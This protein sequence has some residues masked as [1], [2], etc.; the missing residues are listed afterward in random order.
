MF[1]KFEITLHHVTKYMIISMF[2][3]IARVTPNNVN[4]SKL[5]LWLFVY[6]RS[7]D[8][9]GSEQIFLIFFFGGG[10]G[11]GGRGRGGGGWL[12]ACPNEEVT[13]LWK[14]IH[15]YYQPPLFKDD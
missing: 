5:V 13:K 3:S 12:G 15:L 10:G 14:K 11:G 6:V 8:S 1:L 4:C 2:G 7:S 9:K